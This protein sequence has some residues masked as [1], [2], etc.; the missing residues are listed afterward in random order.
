VA[1]SVLSQAWLSYELQ[2]LPANAPK[3]QRVETRR[4]FYAGAQALMGFLSSAPPAG[5]AGGE[6]AAP[7]RAMKRPEPAAKGG[8]A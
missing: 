7:P 8:A 2:V 1:S 4:A 6:K 3:T 5:G